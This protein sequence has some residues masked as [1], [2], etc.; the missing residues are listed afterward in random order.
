MIKGVIFDLD[1]TL[2]NTIEDLQNAMNEMLAVF[3]YPKRNKEQI[4]SAICYGQRE[5]VKRS[6]PHEASISDEIIDKC[7]GRYTLCYQKHCTDNTQPYPMMLQTLKSIKDMGV[8]MSVVTNKA[9]AHAD[10]VIKKCFPEG[11]FDTV[12]GG[13]SF[14]AKPAPAGALYAALRMGAE[15]GECLFIG[16]SDVDIMTGKRA[17]MRTVGVSWGYRDIELLRRAGADF[18]AHAAPDIIDIVKKINF[19]HV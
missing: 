9:Q 18:E 4:L 17:G 14:E 5:F 11:L 2:A 19:D 8:R 3:G 10:G 12:V 6:L 1:G 15:S 7:Q 16:D 13:G